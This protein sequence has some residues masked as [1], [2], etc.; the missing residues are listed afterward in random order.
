MEEIIDWVG[1]NNEE[2]IAKSFNKK[3]SIDFRINTLK[4]NM[5]DVIE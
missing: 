5:K 1:M 3:P 4:T 2:I